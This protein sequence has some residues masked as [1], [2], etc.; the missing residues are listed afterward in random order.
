[1]YAASNEVRKSSSSNIVGCKYV[2]ERYGEAYF[3]G[4]RGSSSG[5]VASED[6]R[7]T[8]SSI[9]GDVGCIKQSSFGTWGY[10][11]PLQQSQQQQQQSEVLIGSTS[12]NSS[13]VQQW[14]MPAAATV[15]AVPSAS[16]WSEAT[17]SWAAAPAVGGTAGGI[18]QGSG[19]SSVP[20]WG[21]AAVH[22]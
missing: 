1:V 20:C 9:N 6:I 17:S 11:L 10:G 22:A 12:S 4:N 21:T 14:T 8:T 19:T 3:R 16:G 5:Y 18:A 2:I 7:N 15:A 13:S